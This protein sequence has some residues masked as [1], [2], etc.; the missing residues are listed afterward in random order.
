[1]GK[2]GVVLRQI[3][4]LFSVGRYAGLSDGQLI[5]RFTSQNGEAAELA[6]AV[7]VERH[8]PMVLRVCRCVLR[9]PND[10]H[11]AFQATFLVLVR[12]APAIRNRESVASWLYGVALRVASCNRSAAARRRTHERRSP[13]RATVAADDE[14]RA[15]LE[16]AVHEEVGRLPDRFRVPVVLCYLEGM[17]QEDAATRLGWPI[18]TVRSRL[19]RARDRLRAGLARRGFAPTAGGI[20]ALLTCETAEAAVPTVLVD[21]TIRIATRSAVRQAMTAGLVPASIAALSEGA[22]RTMLITK[23]KTIAMAVLAMGAFAAGAGV[24]AQSAAKLPAG[25]DSKANP[26]ATGAP[27]A[28]AGTQEL[29]RGRTRR[30]AQQ[31]IDNLNAQLAEQKAKLDETS[32]QLD[33]ANALLG[34]VPTREA[35]RNADRNPAA[36]ADPALG[37]PNVKFES[38]PANPKFATAA[39]AN[40]PGADHKTALDSPEIAETLRAEEPPT[41]SE[42]LRKLFDDR[43]KNVRTAVELVTTDVQGCRFYPLAGPCMTVTMRYKCTVRFDERRGDRTESRVEVVYVD[44]ARLVR[45]TDPEHGHASGDEFDRRELERAADRVKWAESMFAK[46]YVS[47]SQRDAEQFALDRLRTKLVPDAKGTPPKGNSDPATRESAP[48]QERRLRDVERK[49]DQILDALKVM[50]RPAAAPSGTRAF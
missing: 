44:K 22:L 50:S 45:C 18:G 28:P 35:T 27:G 46:G 37:G 21:T 10:A 25:A 15:D 31:L 19:A 2:Q 43:F 33:H 23:L 16:A 1:M 49:L 9:D 11:D 24:L 39:L 30:E 17:T 5:E 47:K 12:K 42:I 48:D 7:L 41:E 14:D 3:H 38:D 36:A 8:G 4:A 40:A 20:A 29:D 13:A 6:F 34:R 26:S 32:R